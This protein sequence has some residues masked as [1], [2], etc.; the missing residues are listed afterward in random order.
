LYLNKVKAGQWWWEAEAGRFL[1]SRTARAIQRNLVSKNP[2]TKTK[3]KQNK[4]LF[5]KV[6]VRFLPYL[7]T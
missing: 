1:S 6:M 7:H 5:N 2:K 4:S 3:T